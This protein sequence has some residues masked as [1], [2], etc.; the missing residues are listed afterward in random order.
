MTSRAKLERSIEQASVELAFKRG[1]I[2]IK[3]DKAMR[4]WPDRMFLGPSSQSFL[5]EFKRPGCAPRKQ[6]EIRHKQLTALGH[7]VSVIT[8][9]SDFASLLDVFCSLADPSV[10]ASDQETSARL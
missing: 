3:L 4:S 8:S 7:P 10:S 6:Q 2:S 5:V 9:L 1:F